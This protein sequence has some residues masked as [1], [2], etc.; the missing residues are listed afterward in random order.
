M[1][2]LWNDACKDVGE[3]ILM[4]ASLKHSS[5]S[6]YINEKGLSISDLQSITD[7]ARIESVRKFAKVE[8][9]RKRAL[10]EKKIIFRERDMI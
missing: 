4:Y 6:Q 10:T 2:K 1:N 9:A 8:V 5:C 7:H 3:S